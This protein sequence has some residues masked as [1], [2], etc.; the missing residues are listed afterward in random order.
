MQKSLR[1]RWGNFSLLQVAFYAAHA[2]YSPY[3]SLYMNEQGLSATMIGLVSTCSSL[4]SILLQPM[5]GML[6]DRLRSVKKVYLTCLSV[7]TL[8]VPVLGMLHAPMLIALWIPMTNVFF[9]SMFSFMDTWLVQSI[10]EIPGKNYGNVRV[11]G[12]VGFMIVV[13][14]SGQLSAEYGA[15]ISFW[16]FSVFALIS[17]SIAVC[18]RHEGVDPTAPKRQRMKLKDMQFGKLFRNYHYI[19]FVI[20]VALVQAAI[21]VK[22]TYL[23]QRVLEAGGDNALY[24]MFYSIGA[25]SEVPILFLSGKI[26]RRFKAS[27]VVRFSMVIY[28]VQMMIFSFPLPAPVLL[29]VQLTQGL[30]YGL[31]L[32]GSVDYLDELA[33]P[34]LKTSALTFASAVYGGLAGIFGS[35]LGGILIDNV[36]IMST[37]LVAAIWAGCGVV[38]YFILSA[39]GRN[40]S[41]SISH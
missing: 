7:L 2:C 35:S 27:S 18:I 1:E 28:A 9:C 24:G 22:A 32:V 14:L 23:P 40:K 41:E 19:V 13:A 10:K 33:P 25:L 29:I 5:W 38:I 12:S 6:C 36:G 15:G 21:T 39:I 20:C 16:C 31:F 34:E 37:Y 26:L 8:M 4:V 17:L 11:W 30:G 3:T